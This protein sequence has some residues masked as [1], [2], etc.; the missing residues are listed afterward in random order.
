MYMCL[1]KKNESVD[2]SIWW[3]IEQAK[4]QFLGLEEREVMFLRLFAP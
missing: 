4:L 2:A 3:L 1:V